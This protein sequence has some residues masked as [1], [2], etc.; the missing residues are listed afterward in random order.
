MIT[1]IDNQFEPFTI[2]MLDTMRAQIAAM[3]TVPEPL[4]KQRWRSTFDELTR[5]PRIVF[6]PYA[7]KQ[8]AERNFPI[9]R[10][11][12]RRIHKKLCKRH[13]GEF[14]MAPTIWTVGDVIFAHPSFEEEIQRAGFA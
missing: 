8:T 14:R 6:T 3:F 13:G 11:R 9:S 2:D 7:L 1:P 5:Q 12:S 10:H 4:L